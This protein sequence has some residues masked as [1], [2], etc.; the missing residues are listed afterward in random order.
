MKQFPK[1]IHDDLGF[2][3]YRLVD[4]RN[5]LTF[6]VGMGSGDR[7]FAHIKEK[8]V[9]EGDEDE[10]TE[11]IKTIREIKN[12]G[13][14]PLHVIHRHGLMK[15]EAFLAEAVLI[16]A[17]PGLT[18]LAGGYGSTDYGPAHA[19]ELIQRYKAEVMTIEPGH[20]VM[21]INV[22]ISTGE[23]NKSFYDAVRYAW[24][25]SI[26]RANKADYVFAVTNG[27]CREVFVPQKPWLPAT[28]ENFPGLGIEDVK[29][30]YGFIGGV[31][32]EDIQER[33]KNKRLP[34]DMQRTKGMASPILYNYS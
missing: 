1:E 24:R 2:Y 9:F 17:I 31:A 8:L 32:P 15:E 3:V 14:E 28:I 4:P 33:Y 26:K 12:V 18:N 7:V 6:Y 5:G 19:S 30:R 16:D 21:A 22:R 23:E 11:K 27:I 20:R 10:L 29:G 34:D 25:V 13:L